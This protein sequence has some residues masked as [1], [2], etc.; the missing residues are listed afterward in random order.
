M[1]FFQIASFSY[2]WA[3]ERDEGVSAAKQ[4]GRAP[5]VTWWSAHG[6]LTLLRVDGLVTAEFKGQ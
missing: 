6:R 1:S 4:D 5:G 3:K 2:N